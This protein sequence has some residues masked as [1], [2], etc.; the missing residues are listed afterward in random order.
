LGRY[1]E[2]LQRDNELVGGC[3]SVSLED[4][5]SGHPPEGLVRK[6]II[7]A[8]GTAALKYQIVNERQGKIFLVENG[9]YVP[10]GR[11]SII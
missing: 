1:D 10:C 7:K 11:T 5:F 2:S 6:D 8:L 3:A 9:D 4:L